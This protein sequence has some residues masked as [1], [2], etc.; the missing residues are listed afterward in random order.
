MWKC[1]RLKMAKILNKEPAVYKK[2]QDNFLRDLRKFHDSKGWVFAET[3]VCRVMAEESL[4]ARLQADLLVHVSQATQFRVTTF[5]L[6]KQIM[7]LIRYFS[8]LTRILNFRT[9]YKLAPS[10][11][12]KEIDLYLLYWLVTAQGGWEKVRSFSLVIDPQ[13]ECITIN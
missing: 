8:K 10:I 5:R 4:A 1:Q 7:K 3:S 13:R 11:N 2:E 6:L 12:G 9:S